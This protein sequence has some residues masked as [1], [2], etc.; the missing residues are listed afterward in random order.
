VL[1]AL[2][3]E[4]EADLLATLSCDVPAPF[5]VNTEATVKN[6]SETTA[7]ALVERLAL[8]ASTAALRASAPSAV[9]EIFIRTRLAQPHG[10]FYGANAIDAATVALL[11]E[12]ALAC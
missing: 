5:A 6:A 12:R 7:R 11:L 2:K 8:L 10:A 4:E 9:T 3:Q 1:R